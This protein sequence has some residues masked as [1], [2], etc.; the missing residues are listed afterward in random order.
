[1][2]R[3]G[4]GPHAPAAPGARAPAMA[5]VRVPSRP[6]V[7]KPEVSL[8]GGRVH[9]SRA[10][11]LGERRSLHLV[12]ETRGPCAAL[13][14]SQSLGATKLRDARPV[15]EDTVLVRRAGLMRRRQLRLPAALMPSRSASPVTLSSPDSLA[16]A[17][18]PP[19]WSLH[20]NAPVTSRLIVG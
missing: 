5:A 11:F 8:A 7:S 14:G 20:L 13:T 6:R 18:A 19:L 10:H 16:P 4:P 1:M 3:A 2:G 9:G 17:P 12:L 15:R